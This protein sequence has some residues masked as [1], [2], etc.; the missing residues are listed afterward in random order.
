MVNDVAIAETMAKS[1][2]KSPRGARLLETDA[3]P[4][5]ISSK[6]DC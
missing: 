4:R 2:S 5:A 6:L 1:V 3:K